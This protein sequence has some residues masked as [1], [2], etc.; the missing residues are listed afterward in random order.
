MSHKACEDTLKE[1]INNNL[2]LITH[3]LM[4]SSIFSM[5]I[6]GKGG[7]YSHAILVQVFCAFC[8]KYLQEK[9]NFN[10]TCLGKYIPRTT[11]FFKGKSNLYTF[12][13]VV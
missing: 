10:F 3:A 12:E 13:K 1:M 6:S 7:A 4:T 8:M 11:D 5:M 9:N 2:V